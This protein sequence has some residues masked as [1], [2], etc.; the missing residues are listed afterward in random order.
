MSQIR[1]FAESFMWSVVSKVID[2]AV[3][4][5][6]IPLMLHYFGKD[7][8]GILI[9]AISTNAYMSLL[10]LGI[11]TGAVKYF[12]QWL[13]EKKYALIHSVSRTS[14]TFYLI[15]GI[16]NSLVLIFLALFGQ[17]LFNI[18]HEQFG[19]LQT[20]FIIMAFYAILNWSTLVF[21]QLLIASERIAFIQQ[22]NIVKS[23][24][25]LLL[26][27]FTIKFNL[28]L[29]SYFVL[30]LTI[31]SIFVIP[32]YIKAKYSNLIQSFLP[33]NDWINFKQIFRYSLSIFAMGVFQFTAT[34]SRPIVLGIFNTTGAGIFSEY[35]IV[36]VFPI[37]I[38][39]IGGMIVTILL[40]ITSKL[41]QQKQHDK[42]AE[43]AYKGTGITSILVCI[44]CF[45]I[46]INSHDILTL[47]VGQKYSFLAPWL[48]LWIFTII[49]YLHNSPISSLVLSTGKTRMLVYSS[50]IAC[51][52]SIIINAILCKSFGVGSAVIG[53][54]VYILI[55]MSFYYLYFN[56]KVLNLQSFKVFRAFLIPTFVAF[57]AYIPLHIFKFDFF[58]T[59]LNILFKTSIWFIFFFGIL[60]IFKVIDL[61]KTLLFIRKRQ[62]KL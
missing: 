25:N 5:F 19:I 2:A 33:G 49:L 43:M 26:I 58:S 47:Y 6:T 28:S 20:M 12:S 11:N 48:N 61:Q 36:E 27:Y 31:N 16:V 39:S 57:I 56:N 38:I 15:I 59:F 13:A 24:V 60:F 30:F 8:Y 14:I 32:Y 35:R 10:D 41:V 42:I 53:Y 55:N 1:Y 50:G 17:H 45:P 37:F 21:N 4:F 52:I 46:I 51:I 23:I 40:P 34:K 62:F 9:L 22:I 29:L 44:L 7:N 54:L 3:K 18:T